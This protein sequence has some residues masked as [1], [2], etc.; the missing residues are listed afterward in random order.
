MAPSSCTLGCGAHAGGPRS[1]HSN[2]PLCQAPQA[3]QTPLWSSE[4]KGGSGT[5]NGLPVPGATG[6][7]SLSCLPV[8]S[9]CPDGSWGSCPCCAGGP[10]VEEGPP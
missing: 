10:G 8:C 3:P 2:H 7:S 9:H 4:R 6:G 1:P 5:L